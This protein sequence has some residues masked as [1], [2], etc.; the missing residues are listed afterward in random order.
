MSGS[1]RTPNAVRGFLPGF[2]YQSA[3]VL[4]SSVVYIEAVY[5][6]RTSYALKTAN[7]PDKCDWAYG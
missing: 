6:Q 1:L 2:A 5:A 7:R 3:G 4:A